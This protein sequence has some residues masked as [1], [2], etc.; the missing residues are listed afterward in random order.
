MLHVTLLGE[1]A[2]T[3]NGTGSVRIRSSRTVALI[4]FLAV[5]AGAPQARQWIAGLF[6]PDFDGRTGADQLAARAA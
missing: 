1:Q 3:D 2:I 6:W 4:A 5:H